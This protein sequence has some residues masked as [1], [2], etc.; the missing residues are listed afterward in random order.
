MSLNAFG[1]HQPLLFGAC[2]STD[3]PMVEL[4][5]GFYSTPFIH[6][7]SLG[8]NRRA[9]SLD[10]SRG[11]LTFMSRYR[12]GLH[13]V[14]LLDEKMRMGP[15]GKVA[16]GSRSQ[17]FFVERQTAVLEKKFAA[18]GEISVVF[19]DHDPAFLRQ[20]A[21]D[22]FADRARFIVAHDTESPAH[23][24]YDFSRFR[25]QLSDH[26]QPT[27]TTVVS[28]MADCEP[29]RRFLWA[30]G[31]VGQR[32]TPPG[33]V[34]LQSRGEV[35]RATFAVAP[36]QGDSY[37]R[38]R[39]RTMPEGA[40]ELEVVGRSSADPKKGYLWARPMKN[41]ALRSPTEAGDM[42][43]EACAMTT[44]GNLSPHEVDVLELRFRAE[45]ASIEVEIV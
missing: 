43:V 40:C 38:L 45:D 17:A 31:P 37:L 33:T 9:Y 18:M 27:G 21:I 4:G 6:A 22:W 44:H 32:M 10:T 25:H 1:T 42:V 7:L 15:D 16:M 11:Y 26:Y 5:T 8:Q 28:N 36:L 24:G 3:G 13:K 12:E 2:I 34:R 29:L 30:R 39:V 41:G 20:P 23:Y 14:S 35:A 19:I